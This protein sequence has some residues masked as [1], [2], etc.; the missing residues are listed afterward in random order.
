MGQNNRNTLGKIA[1][2]QI[3]TRVFA[4]Q[5]DLIFKFFV[6]RSILKSIQVEFS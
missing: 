5:M 2:R 1:L 3:F 6:A 4:I